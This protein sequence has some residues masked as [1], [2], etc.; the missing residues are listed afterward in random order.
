[1]Y[2]KLAEDLQVREMYSKLA[3]D[4]QVREMYSK[5]AEDLQVR[6]M[7]SK[8]TED[9]QVREMYSK[10][11]EDIQVRLSLIPVF[12]DGH[13]N[14]RNVLFHFIQYWKVIPFPLQTIVL[15]VN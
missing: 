4:L 9:L 7:Y 8:L 6:E 11:A 10:L 15:K 14:N 2:S 1:M 12:S 3:E 13:L 5:L